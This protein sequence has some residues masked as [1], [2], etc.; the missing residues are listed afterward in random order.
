[1]PTVTA[2]KGALMSEG[3][4]PT[5]DLHS[6]SAQ[7]SGPEQ[8]S[9]Q[10]APRTLSPGEAAAEPTP[11]PAGGQT[12][13]LDSVW[14]EVRKRVFIKLPFSLGVA[15]AMQAAVPITFEGEMFVIGLSPRDYP[16]SSHL[17]PDQVK[18][19]IESILRQA[20]R[21][22]IHLEVIEGTTLEEWEEIKERRRLAQE[23]VV[24]MAEREFSE[25]QMEDVLN[26]VVAEIRHRI[27]AQRDRGLPHVRAQL[28][29]DVVPSF[30]DAIEMLFSD[31]N[32]HEARRA[33]GRALDRV[34]SYLDVPPLTFAL[35][36]ERYRR[37]HRVHP[38]HTARQ[39]AAS[40]HAQASMKAA[41]AAETPAEPGAP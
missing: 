16:L 17:V 20:A 19:T 3:Q 7:P 15:E 31:L 36:M 32:T 35:E 26:Q 8:P 2:S 23:A 34:S 21:R 18:N 33:V 12:S 27:T 29:L 5:R 24:A 10:V 13:G 30:S 37:A 40:E 22:N 11:A 4:N 41:T 9:F 1:V 14:K 25:Q 6:G 39:Q 38:T 28:L